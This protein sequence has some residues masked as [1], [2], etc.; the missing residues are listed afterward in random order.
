MGWITSIFQ[1]IGN[2]SPIGKILIGLAGIIEIGIIY[3]CFDENDVGSSLI[4]WF[5]INIA[6]LS[7]GFLIFFSI[8]ILRG[9]GELM[10]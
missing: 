7:L 2:A 5:T 1:A 4:A 10:V 8:I 9:L 3:S 6:L